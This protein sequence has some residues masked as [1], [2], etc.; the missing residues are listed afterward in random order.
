MPTYLV[1]LYM[2][3][4]GAGGLRQLAARARA[5]A[6]TLRSDGTPARYLRSFLLTEDETLFSFFEAPSIEAVKEASR[7][8]GLSPS[9]ITETVGA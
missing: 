6:G 1:E 3:R 2:S 4:S 5:A 8:A 9:R 7:L